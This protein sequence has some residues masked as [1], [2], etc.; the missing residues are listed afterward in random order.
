MQYEASVIENQAYSKKETIPAFHTSF[1]DAQDF[2][3]S[4]TITFDD[5][6]YNL[7]L[8]HFQHWRDAGDGIPGKEGI[9]YPN[10][11]SASEMDFRDSLFG[12]L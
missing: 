8:I 11:L 10:D 6:T 9:L 4:T 2:C 3:A 1:Y 12:R 7:H 5:T